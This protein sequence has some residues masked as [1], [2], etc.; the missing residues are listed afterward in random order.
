MP[1][2]FCAHASPATSRQAT[3]ASTASFDLIPS[4]FMAPVLYLLSVEPNVFHAPAVETAG[5]HRRQVLEVGLLAARKTRVEQH[6]P[7]SI[8]CQ[9]ALDF[10]HESAP[11]IG[12][13]F[14]RLRVDQP[15]RLRIAVAG[16]I[17]LGTADVVFVKFLVGLVESPGAD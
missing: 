7:R 17:A 8:L 9:L 3:A 4:S 14:H 12:I 10:P 15:V 11:L 5:G 16:E 2:D 1:P 6:R 13:R